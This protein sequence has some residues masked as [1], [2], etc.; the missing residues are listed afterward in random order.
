MDNDVRVLRTDRGLSQ[1]ALATV[2]G[3]PRQTVNAIET[4]R[5][6]PSLPL[7]RS[8]SPGTSTVPSRSCSMSTD[9]RTGTSPD[10]RRPDTPSPAGR[11]A[12]P[13]LSAIVGSTVGAALVSQGRTGEGIAIGGILVAY[14]VFLVVAS[15]RSETVALLRGGLD[16]ER[17]ESINLRANA[18][19]G[20]VLTVVLVGGFVVSLVT[21]GPD[22]AVW[23]ALCA[24]AGVTFTASTAWYSA[25]G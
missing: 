5:Y 11:W 9:D 3:V 17:R 15:R 25:R 23:S 13:L 4:G 2:L 18:V 14:A 6:D 12:A 16:D 21:D 19:T 8:A 7:A 10:T 24:V 20:V 1:A 22:T